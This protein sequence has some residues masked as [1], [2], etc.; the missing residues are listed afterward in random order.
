MQP[1]DIPVWKW[2]HVSL[3][4]V[5]GLPKTRR[6]N[7]TVWVIVDRLTKSAHFLQ[8]RVNLPL[9]Q[10]VELYVSEIVQLHRVPVTIVYDRDT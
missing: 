6:K 1:L 10:L 3:D 5:I 8:M 9:Q 7:N 2:E 4:F